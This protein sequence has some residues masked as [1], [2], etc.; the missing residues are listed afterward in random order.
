MKLLLLSAIVGVMLFY[1]IKKYT[2][3]RTTH[4]TYL[5]KVLSMEHWEQSKDK[6]NIVLSVM[7]HDFIHLA[8]EQQV[9]KIIEKFWHGISTYVVLTVDVKKLP[10]N[11]VLE[12]NPGG[13]TKYYHLYNGTIPQQ[14]VV[15]SKI[16]NR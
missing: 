6:Q 7:D 2:N 15:E 4:P 3:R 16:V 10:G 1:G 9:D 12:S 8:T 14:S 11:L 5:Y 13:V